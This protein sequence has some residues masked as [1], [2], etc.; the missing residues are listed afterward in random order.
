MKFLMFFV[1]ISDEKQGKENQS[2]NNSTKKKNEK[3]L[4]HKAQVR[5]PVKRP[6]IDHKTAE[7]RSDPQK[8]QVHTKITTFSSSYSNSFQCH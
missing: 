2:S 6:P 7:K 4:I 3:S 5:T 1:A 8:L